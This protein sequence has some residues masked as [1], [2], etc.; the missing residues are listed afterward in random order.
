MEEWRLITFDKPRVYTKGIMIMTSLV[1]VELLGLCLVVGLARCLFSI[2]R[3]GVRFVHAAVRP[4]SAQ[5]DRC[6]YG[7]CFDWL[8]M[9]LYVCLL[10][11]RVYG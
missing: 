3:L 5:T 9:E 7:K 6:V 1:V 8:S 2:R 11:R 4:L 10:D